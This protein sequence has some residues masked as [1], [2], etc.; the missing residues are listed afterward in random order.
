MKKIPPVIVYSSTLKGFVAALIL[1]GIYVT[2]VTLISGW[3]FA[4]EQ[5][6]KFW[7]FILPLAL[8]FGIQVGLFTYLRSAIKQSA[9]SRVLA[10]SGTTSTAAMIS[11]CAHYLVNLL[12]IL[13]AVGIITV[14][15]QYQV[16]LFWVGLA[17]NFAGILY[18][19]N[20]VIKFSKGM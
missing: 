3:E 11:C 20:R 12:P 14:I 18:M 6:A 19:L 16:Q 13:G 5:F 8:G 2:V 4:Q 9:S 15:A 7:Y 10:V 17:F 1:L